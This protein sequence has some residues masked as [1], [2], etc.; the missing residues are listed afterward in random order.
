[1]NRLFMTTASVLLFSFGTSTGQVPGQPFGLVPLTTL[2]APD[3]VLNAFELKAATIQDLVVP[4]NSRATFQLKVNLGG[5]VQTLL[6]RPHSLLDPNFKLLVDDGALTRQVATPTEVTYQ[7]T[8]VEVPGSS[9]AA[10]LRNG[11][12]SAHILLP[13][14]TWAIQPLRDGLIRRNCWQR[15]WMFSIISVI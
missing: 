14:M 13:G 12:F 7:G 8:V 11:Q 3:D 9:V 6:L 4:P 5:R 15:R 1:M 2:Q 10:D